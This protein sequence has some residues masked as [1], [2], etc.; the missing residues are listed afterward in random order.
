MN[1]L[2]KAVGTPLEVTIKGKP[3]KLSPLSINDLAEAESRIRSRTMREFK[4]ACDGK[5]DMEIILSIAQREVSQEELNKF[6][7]SLEGLLYKA[8]KSL[9]KQYPKMNYDDLALLFDSTNMDELKEVSVIINKLNE[10][11]ASPLAPTLVEEVSL[12]QK[13]VP[14]SPTTTQAKI[15]A[16]FQS[17]SS[18]SD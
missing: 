1:S 5:I 8:W 9:Q 15:P 13:P 14:L 16:C 3:F 18:I 17:Q 12:G 7:N 2:E 11:T 4:Q 6:D 10:V